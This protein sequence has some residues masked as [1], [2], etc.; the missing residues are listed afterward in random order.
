MKKQKYYVVWIGRQTGI[1]KSWG[2]CE[3]Q[4]KGYHGAKHKSFETLELAEKA[5]NGSSEDYIG[6]NESKSELTAE[7]LMLI[8]NPIEDSIAVDAAWNTIS[9]I[10]EYQIVYT[11]DK[12]NIFKSATYEDG[13]I[14]I[15]EF[16]AL[17]HALAHCKQKNIPLPIYSDS[18]TALKWTKD[19]EAHTSH[20]RSDK[21]VELFN[22]LNRAETWLKENEYENK[23][24][25]WETA[26]WGENPADYGRK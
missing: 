13:T 16:L 12:K 7:Q 23:I 18:V 2:E 5:S 24:L 1:F 6:S 3:E 4:I 8:G 25:K 9:G 26:A 17:V 21:N 11:K 15:V 14:N 22:L 20:K 10:V 19:K